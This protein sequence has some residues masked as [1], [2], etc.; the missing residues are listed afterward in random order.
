MANRRSGKFSDPE[1][2]ASRES[3]SGVLAGPFMTGA[4]LVAQNEP[5]DH[6]ARHLVV[7]EAEAPEVHAKSTAL[8]GDVMV[9]PEI[10]HHL[11]PFGPARPHEKSPDAAAVTPGED[12]AAEL[13]VR[14]ER[15]PGGEPLAGAEVNLFFHGFGFTRKVSAVTDAEGRATLRFEAD[16]QP[17]AVTAMPSG[18]C[19][20][21]VVPD[22]RASA[23]LA[24]PALPES[25]GHL[26]WWHERIG[27]TDYREDRGHGI[28]VGV[29]DT[30]VGPHPALAH[31]RTIGAFVDDDFDPSGAE[32]VHS[33]GSH[34]CGIIGARP[35][36]PADFG[37]VAPGVSLFSARIFPPEG[38]ATQL[39][40]AHAIDELSRHEKVDLINLSLGSDLGSDIARDAIVD[41]LERGTLCIC[42]AGNTG[43]DVMYP[44]AFPE[45]V[46]VTALGRIG[47][48]PSGSVPSMRAPKDRSRFGDDDLFLDLFSCHGNGVSSSAPGVGIVS[49]VPER[50][51]MKHPYAA[52][53]GTSMAAAVVCGTL[54]VLL[55]GSAEYLALPRHRERAE[56]A[57][58]IL[59]R[60]CRSVGLDAGLQGL[61]VPRV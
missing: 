21:M 30:G 11:G 9:E 10:H 61:G 52:M 17:S 18:D 32:D 12:N 8:P 39:G 41:A 48:G 37:G 5:R 4:S 50:L 57:R 34:I 44:G 54:A 35:T 25:A 33:H 14:V 59:E 36:R 45:T 7:F 22:P 51:G 47:W 60:S 23:V 6:T 24:C 38:T 15:R 55:S 40:I 16:L 2:L 43:G 1:K 20:P 29:V 42:A 58:T 56:M 3:M 13:S 19:W 49:T 31:V 27:Q 26:G 46:A 53:G 28:G